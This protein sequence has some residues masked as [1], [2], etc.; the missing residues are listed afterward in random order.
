VTYAENST[1][2]YS[3]VGPMLNEWT[4][5][6]APVA[7]Y[8]M[9]DYDYDYNYTMED[10]DYDYEGEDWDYEGEDWD[11]EGEDW[12]YEGE[13]WDYE[14]EDWDYEGEDW[15]YEE[16]EDWEFDDEDWD[17]E[18][19]TTYDYDYDYDYDS[20]YYSDYDYDYDYDYDTDYYSMY[21]YGYDDY[22][23]AY[24]DYYYMYGEDE[25][26]Y[27]EDDYMYG[28]EEMEDTF[29]SEARGA[30]LDYFWYALDT[31]DESNDLSQNATCS[32]SA[33]CDG[34]GVTMCCVNIIST[35]NS[36]AM[37]QMFRCM[38]RGVAEMSFEQTYTSDNGDD[39]YVNMKCLADA[40]HFIK[41]GIATAFVLIASLY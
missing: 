38:N 32:T 14:G 9:G 35:S 5:T 30:V 11:Y 40:A 15:D 1:D 37:D 28:G 24:D 34:N 13:D 18:Y 3:M 22:G 25:Y 4:F 23:Y 2:P 39:M 36:G 29:V 7:M 26:Y 27:G 10:Y 33:D 6:E 8:D 17:Y 21:G 19:D 16:G 41:A 12:D 31:N 20:Y